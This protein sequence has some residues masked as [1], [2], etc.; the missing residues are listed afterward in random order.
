MLAGT[1]YASGKLN[2]RPHFLVSTA[3]RAADE[4]YDACLR[5]EVIRIPSTMNPAAIVTAHATLKWLVRS[6]S[7]AMAQRMK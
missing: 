4:G 1:R 6:V 2:K 5:G 3:E 7:G